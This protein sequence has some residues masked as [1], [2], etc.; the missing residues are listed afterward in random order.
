ML[1]ATARVHEKSEQ[2]MDETAKAKADRL[3][4]RREQRQAKRER[5]SD[6][7]Q[8]ATERAK[9]T[10]QYDADALKRIGGRTGLLM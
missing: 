9:S 2:Q 7:P 6:T 10:K 4:K 1:I 3:E 5:T 8:A